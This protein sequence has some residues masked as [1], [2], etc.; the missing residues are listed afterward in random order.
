MVQNLVRVDG[1][2]TTIRLQ[3][4]RVQ[5]QHVRGRK[6]GSVTFNENWRRIRP[7][8]L[9]MLTQQ[10]QILT[11]PHAQFQHSRAGRQVLGQY[12]HQVS[13]IV[14]LCHRDVLLNVLLAVVVTHYNV[15][16]SKPFILV[17][18]SSGAKLGA[19][20]SFLPRKKRRALSTVLGMSSQKL[21]LDILSQTRFGR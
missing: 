4:H 16:S 18:G 13:S 2:E 12:R 19:L 14:A 3:R 7:G 1:V 15:R 11:R 6:S 17:T 9:K 8:D 21:F 5:Q 20:W 10:D